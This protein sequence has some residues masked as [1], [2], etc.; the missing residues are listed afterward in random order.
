[1][2]LKQDITRGFVEYA[3]AGSPSASAKEKQVYKQLSDLA[4]VVDMIWAAIDEVENGLNPVL[5]PQTQT[6]GG[7]EKEP[8]LERVPLAEEINR[9]VLG[10]SRMYARLMSIKNR[11]EI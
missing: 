8:T 1:M 9:S 2:G 10:L 11:L 3:E 4:H 7:N 5:S 6:E